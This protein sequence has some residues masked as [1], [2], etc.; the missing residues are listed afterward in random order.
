MESRMAIWKSCSIKRAPLNI[1]GAS[2]R[3]PCTSKL[4]LTHEPASSELSDYARKYQPKCIFAQRLLS[5]HLSEQT[6]LSTYRASLPASDEAYICGTCQKF[7]DLLNCVEPCVVHVDDHFWI[8][9][10]K[11]SFQTQMP[12]EE[13]AGCTPSCNAL[14][15]WNEV[16]SNDSATCRC[17]FRVGTVA[18]IA[19]A[20]IAVVVP[21]AV[22][23]RSAACA[24][25]AKITQLPPAK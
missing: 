21:I 9:D 17:L 25:R 23:A 8:I 4:S 13:A 12:L 10:P 16:F 20:C 15:W 7:S 19:V 22:A 6:F 2:I 1:F 24:S 14:Y 11:S 5:I 3:I 18:C